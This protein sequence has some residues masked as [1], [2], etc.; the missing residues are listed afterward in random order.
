M[1]ALAGTVTV[2]GT[3]TAALLLTRP[4]LNPPSGA[5]EFSVTEQ[6]SAPAPVSDPFV[7][8]KAVSTG[9]G[10]DAPGFM[11]WPCRRTVAVGTI[12]ELLLMTRFPESVD[13]PVGT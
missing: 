10:V 13:A 3:D 11:P 9:A 4:T 8:E 6:A 12:I 7:H 5:E 2:G 1:V